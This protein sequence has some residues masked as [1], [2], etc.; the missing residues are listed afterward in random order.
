MVAWFVRESLSLSSASGG[1]NPGT[2][3]FSDVP[4]QVTIIASMFS[5]IAGS[6]GN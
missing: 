4:E 1:S 5:E 2:G 3:D 6:A